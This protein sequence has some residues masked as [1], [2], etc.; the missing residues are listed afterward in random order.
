[1]NYSI[2]GH[3]SGMSGGAV[4]SDIPEDPPTHQGG[5]K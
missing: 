4:H 5:S 1:M 3:F 2:G